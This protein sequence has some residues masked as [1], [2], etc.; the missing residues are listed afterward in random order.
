MAK[1]K[2]RT[3][4]VGKNGEVKL[5]PDVLEAIGHEEGEDVRIFVDTRRKQVR[6][7]RHV[8]DPWA[9]ALKQKD[10]KGFDDLMDEQKGRED[11]AKRLFE[12]RLKD[13]PKRD[14]KP[15]DDPDHWR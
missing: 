3:L 11:A 7:E 2:P 10:E 5:P 9:D 1:K 13:P 14:R 15:E 8:D 12:E 6:L 4:K